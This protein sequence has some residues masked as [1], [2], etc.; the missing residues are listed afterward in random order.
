MRQLN[1][2]GIPPEFHTPG[3]FEIRLAVITLRNRRRTS[4]YK[5]A[6]DCFPDCNDPSRVIAESFQP[7]QHGTRSAGTGEKEGGQR[8]LGWRTEVE[9]RSLGVSQEK[10]EGFRSDRKFS[11]IF[12]GQSESRVLGVV[13]RMQKRRIQFP[14]ARIPLF[15]V[16][17]PGRVC[18]APFPRGDIDNLRLLI[19]TFQSRPAAE[20]KWKD[21]SDSAEFLST[22]S[23]RFRLSR[24]PI[25]RGEGPRRTKEGYTHYTSDGNLS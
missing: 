20:P 17:N 10:G 15:F 12:P 16:R 23:P 8:G 11:N 6:E 7:T 5:A 2:T 3:R 25:S 18:T 4:V 9:R 14:S 22:F 19:S 13:R 21:N 24:H 1:D